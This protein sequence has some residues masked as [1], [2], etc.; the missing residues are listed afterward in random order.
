MR[1]V[2]KV[3][4]VIFGGF[5]F[6]LLSTSYSVCAVRK[7]F[8]PSSDAVQQRQQQAQAAAPTDQRQSDKPAAAAA[9]AP[10]AKPFSDELTH[11]SRNV[12]LASGAAAVLLARPFQGAAAPLVALSML[13]ATVHN[14]CFGA[15][16]P[17]RLTKTVLHPLVTCTTLTWAWSYL[18]GAATGSSF[19]AM[20]RGYRIGGALSLA[21]SGA[22]DL[23][24][25][26]L[27]P[28]VV[29]L[30][31]SI[32]ERRQLIRQNLKEVVT[33]T[34]VSC[35]G[36]LFGTALVVRLLGLATA[37]L[38]LSLLPRNITSALAAAIADIVGA[39]KPLAVS[40]AVVTGL[41]GANFGASILDYF[42]IKDPAVRGLGIGSAAHGLGTAAFVDEKDAFPF[43]AIGMTLTAIFGTVLVSVPVVQK[44]ALRIALG[45]L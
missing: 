31:V 2:V 41:I 15:R 23:L 33:A 44:L 16:L 3:F 22:G 32:Y 17:K 28:A 6:S 13:A 21:S 9:A 38:R 18:L 34:G 26:V 5:L 35:V 14:F 4:S 7:I 20:I 45:G 30:G 37:E 42:G 29:S 12:A 10:A 40:F 8:R 11:G 25:F 24:T 39:N 19:L 36:G 43:A 27:G 1:Q